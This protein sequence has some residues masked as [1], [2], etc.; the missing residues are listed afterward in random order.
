M[1][2]EKIDT[3]YCYIDDA[4]KNPNWGKVY[5]TLNP[6]TYKD[7]DEKSKRLYQDLF[8]LYVKCSNEWNSP[9][10]QFGAP[11][12]YNIKETSQKLFEEEGTRYASDFIGVNRKQ[13]HMAGISDAAIVEYLKKQRTIGGHMIFPVG[14]YPTINQAKGC[15]ILDRFDFT[16][17]ELRNYFI[18]LGNMSGDTSDAYSVKYNGQLGKSFEVYKE[19]I[20]RFCIS[21]SDGIRNFKNF[22]SYWILGMFVNEDEE[23]KVISLGSSDLENGKISCIE[24]ENKEPYFPGLSKFPNRVNIRGIKCA[25]SGMC[26]DEREIVRENFERYI[27]NMNFLIAKRNKMIRKLFDKKGTY[28]DIKN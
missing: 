21:D 19:W 2:E 8:C 5:D 3:T 9:S 13:A 15:N 28:D 26:L 22:I 1:T 7:P 16:L 27:G 10:F 14:K 12:R 6:D 4:M 18:Y 24:A 11:V 25:L 20:K 17:A 23:C